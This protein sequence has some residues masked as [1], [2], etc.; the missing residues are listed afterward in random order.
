MRKVSD[1]LLGKCY[2]NNNKELIKKLGKLAEKNSVVMGHMKTI[3]K[4]TV[5]TGAT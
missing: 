4:N 5:V 1:G 3:I 2:N